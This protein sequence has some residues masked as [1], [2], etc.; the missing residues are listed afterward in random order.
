MFYLLNLFKLQSD[1]KQWGTRR[2]GERSDFKV[3]NILL[4][5]V[6]LKVNEKVCPCAFFFNVEVSF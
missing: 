4:R 3:N 6:P 5:G 2:F 1:R